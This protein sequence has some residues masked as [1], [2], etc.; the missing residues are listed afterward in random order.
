M[1]CETIRQRTNSPCKPI[2]E[3]WQYWLIFV[4]VFLSMA[5]RYNIIILYRHE[6]KKN[7]RKSEALRPISK[8]ESPSS[9][10]QYGGVKCLLKCGPRSEGCADAISCTV[11]WN[12][13]ELACFLLHICSCLP[14]TSTLKKESL[15]CFE[16]SAYF[17]GSHVDISEEIELYHVGHILGDVTMMFRRSSLF[18]S[19][20]WR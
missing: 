6:I 17:T 2:T 7:T 4:V 10:L 19:S 11:R 15:C 12:S 3:L 14:Y 18:S 1:V 9:L 20:R 8:S 5:L 13:A 16:T